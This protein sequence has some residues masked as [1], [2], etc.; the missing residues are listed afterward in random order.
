MIL[1][2]D[3]LCHLNY[4]LTLFNNDEMERAKVQFDKFEA[5]FETLDESTKSSDPEVAQQ[6]QALLNALNHHTID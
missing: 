5:I 4:A 1:S 2:R 6:R 3:H